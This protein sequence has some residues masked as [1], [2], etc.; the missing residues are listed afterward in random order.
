ML[1]LNLFALKMVHK[2]GWA[3]LGSEGCKVKK[4]LLPPGFDD[5]SCIPVYTLSVCEKMGTGINVK[6]RQDKNMQ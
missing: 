4:L 6:D 1:L 2:N 5:S 3:I